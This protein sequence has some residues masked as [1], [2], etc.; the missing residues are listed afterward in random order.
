MSNGALPEIVAALTSQPHWRIVIRPSRYQQELIPSLSDCMK[1]LRRTSVRLRGW[2]FPQLGPDHDMQL[3]KNFVGFA[4]SIIGLEYW[5]FYQSGQ[6]V[7]LQTLDE[8]FARDQL[9]EAARYQLS[10]FPEHRAVDWSKVPG[11]ISIINFLYTMTEIFE[12]TARLCL[13]GVYCEN[14]VIEIALKDIKGFILTMEPPR[15]FP[16]YCKATADTLEHSWTIPSNVLITDGADKALEAVK[17]FFERFGWNDPNIDSLRAD[18]QQF[19]RLA[20]SAP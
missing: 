3:G 9:E 10:R 8:I 2:D 6:F 4:S 12:F 16:K 7:H 17:W 11:F 14:C 5:R 20:E 19:L 18:Q 15:R 13:A 1:I